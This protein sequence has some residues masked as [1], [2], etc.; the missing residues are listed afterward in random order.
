MRLAERWLPSPGVAR[1]F[2]RRDE[3][4]ADAVSGRLKGGRPARDRPPGAPA[5]SAARVCLKCTVMTNVPDDHRAGLRPPQFRLS[6]LLWVV[7]GVGMLCASFT[8]FGPHAALILILLVTVVGAHVAGNALGTQL[9]AN[10]NQPIDRGGRQPAQRS[11]RPPAAE[12]FAPTS[13]L[14]DRRSLGLPV[15]VATVAGGVLTAAAGGLMMIVVLDEVPTWTA[16]VA[17]TLA[18]GA[19]GA[20]GT[21]MAFS[22]IQV[23]GGALWRATRSADSDQK[24]RSRG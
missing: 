6:T 23:A 10:G 16:I 1:R 22:F 8:Y 12:D 5:L 19:L 17:G 20:M 3:R 9:R 7:A 24:P 14:H 2:R 13:E 21:F 4:S 15:V 11:R 18:C